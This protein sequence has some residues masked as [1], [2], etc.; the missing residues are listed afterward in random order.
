MAKKRVCIL[1]SKDGD[2]FEADRNN[3]RLNHLIRE[4]YNED[5]D[6]DAQPDD[7]PIPL[8]N[9]SSKDLKKVIEFCDYFHIN[10]MKDIDKPLRS[11][12]ME[13]CVTKWYSEFINL[14]KEEVFSLVM[15]A[16]YLDN[17]QLLELCCAKVATFIKGRTPE[18]IRS[19]FEIENDFS[20][21]EEQRIRE[22]NK[23]CAEFV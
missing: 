3:M 20:H 12:N 23:W 6:E 13:E 11:S 4:M 8:P 21:E 10:P 19:L 2:M 9:V 18:E 15:A 14:P 17:K 1:C 5:I 16:N 7:T 22:D